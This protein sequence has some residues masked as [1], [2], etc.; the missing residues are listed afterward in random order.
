[1][2]SHFEHAMV[3]LFHI[4]ACVER[5]SVF[6]HKDARRLL[7]PVLCIWCYCH[8][9]SRAF[10]A[11]CMQELFGAMVDAVMNDYTSLDYTTETAASVLGVLVVLSGASETMGFASKVDNVVEMEIQ[12]LLGTS[13]RLMLGGWR[14]RPSAQ[15]ATTYHVQCLISE[16]CHRTDRYRVIFE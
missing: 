8:T 5:I 10:L 6:L 9:A 1:M 13:S 4:L 12:P 16:H 11:K 2:E 15:H 14:D 7:R 3:A